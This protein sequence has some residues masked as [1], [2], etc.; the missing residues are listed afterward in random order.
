MN[1]HLTRNN[2]YV[3]VWYQRQFLLPGESR[4][5]YLDKGPGGNDVGAAT[6]TQRGGQRRPPVS[7]LP[8]KRC[9]CTLDLYTTQFGNNLNDDIERFLFGQID[10][11][12]STA[13]RALVSGNPS[14]IHDGFQDFFEYLDAQKLRTPKGLDWIKEA[15][16]ELTQVDL[17]HE[18]QALRLMHCTMW[19]EG[20]REIVTAEHSDV[21]FIVSDHPVAV[22]NRAI[23]PIAAGGTEAKDPS[24]SLLGTQ[25]VFALNANTCLI[26]THVEY[27]KNPRTTDLTKRR[28]NARYRGG[29][30]V[31]TDAF[32][33]LR[34]LSREAVTQ[35]NLLLKA[36]SKRY[37]AA[38]KREWLYPE[39]QYSGTWADISEA[40]RPRD[41]LWRFGGEMFVK[42]ADGHVH[43]Q[44]AFGRQSKSHEYLAKK[45]LKDKLR[46]NDDCGCGSG[47]K[48]KNCCKQLAKGDRPTW[49]VLSIRE[50]N[51]ILCRG[52]THMLGL[53]AGRSWEDVRRE[54]RDDQVV[55]IHEL[56][57]DLWPTETD[58]AELL[59]RA[60]KDV[61][62]A[63]YLGALDARTIAPVVTGWLEYFDQVIVAHPFVNAALIRPEFSPTHRPSDYKQQTLKNIYALF[64]LEPFIDA[65]YVHL[66]PNPMDV[67]ITFAN[68]V[69]HMAEQRT[70]DWELDSKSADSLLD[71]ARDD[72]MRTLSRLPA[73]RLHK[74]IVE[75]Q[76]GTSAE[77]IE[78]AVAEVKRKY[79]QDPLTLMQPLEAG[80]DKGE[81]KMI[82][83][84][85]LEAALYLAA[86]TGSTIYTDL[87]AH[88]DHLH[89]HTDA[90][91]AGPLPAD[92]RALSDTYSSIRLPINMN[93]K[94]VFEGRVTGLRPEMRYAIRQLSEIAERGISD[95]KHQT[96]LV[97]RAAEK[98]NAHA[99]PSKDD[100]YVEG[101]LSISTPKT[102]F[103]RIEVSR[104][105]LTYAHDPRVRMPHLAMFIRTAS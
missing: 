33:R 82:K 49:D 51:L 100:W 1:Q 8:L 90:A 68:S 46:P 44:D 39:N 32:V 97:K 47:A 58:L 20:V 96:Q 6:E 27:A 12:G 30:L 76:P 3:P 31:R 70:K 62:R 64:I 53:D 16:P 59:P 78:A 35:I 34:H 87:Q 10:R 99:K 65:G 93:W 102:G 55:A 43:Y 42:Y 67:D 52:V 75:S 57:A 14:E 11:T 18:M 72:F 88:W 83:G 13:V 50:R 24:I 48:F 104:L 94:S 63:V 85:G 15:Y 86:F 105:L 84:Y 17:M 21:K 9:F 77:V 28:T 29:G 4:L 66:V 26:L 61:F 74:L 73:D 2:H 98:A 38:G 54:I 79:A 45:P 41:E 81:V 36:Q 101:R 103:G 56:Y 60:R 22:Y 80:Q 5:H 71:L 37:V 89:V 7:L 91:K 19:A 92:L 23:V 25:T 40:L 95:S 69:M